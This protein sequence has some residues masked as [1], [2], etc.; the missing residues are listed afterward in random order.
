MVSAAAALCGEHILQIML[1]LHGAIDI[2]CVSRPERHK[3]SCPKSF[4]TSH[5]GKSGVR[6]E[7]QTNNERYES[8]FQQR[9]ECISTCPF[10]F[11]FS[12]IKSHRSKTHLLVHSINKER[13]KSKHY[14][15]KGKT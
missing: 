8:G 14:K 9:H 12:F 7:F 2:R 5:L 6:G 13:I 4:S 15:V 10:R 3:I 1:T 11:A